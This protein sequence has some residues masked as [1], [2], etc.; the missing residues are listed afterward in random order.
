M[1]RW[2]GAAMIYHPLLMMYSLNNLIVWHKSKFYSTLYCWA[3]LRFQLGCSW[4]NAQRI[5]QLNQQV[6]G[7]QIRTFSWSPSFKYYVIRLGGLG[8]SRPSMLF[9]SQGAGVQNLE[10]P[11]DVIL[12]RS[13]R[14]ISGSLNE[15]KDC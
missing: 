5:S 9:M 13:L 10:T 3:Q 15:N 6:R 11:D 4:L 12:E 2:V 7:G 1:I 14:P 8:G